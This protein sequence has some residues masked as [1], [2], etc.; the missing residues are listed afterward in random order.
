MKKYFILIVCFLCVLL[1]GSCKK[2]EKVIT[3]GATPSPH[4]EI[5]N[6]KAVQDYVKSK[7]YTL[8][9]KVYQDYIT[10]NKALNDSGL[11]ANYFQ[12]IPYLENQIEEF[13]YKISAACQV[14]NEP[15]NLY[16]KTAYTTDS[17]KGKTIYI[18]NDV[19]N[20][21]RA[22]KLLKSL[23]FIDSY[24]VTD[25]NPQHPV[26]ASTLGVKVECIAEGLLHKKVDEGGYAI[27]PG[28][29]ALTAW[30]TSTA[31]AYKLDGESSEVAYPNIIA[32]RTEDLNSEKINVLVEALS[33]P[34]VKAYIEET[35][36]PTVNFCFA[37][38]R[39]K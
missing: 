38:L 9:V 4:A 32:C 11:D 1:L 3:V 20:A 12:H 13:G 8:K 36:G 29:F 22:F 23:G 31:T 28:N 24:D 37:D 14:H 19:E 30:G 15:L 33:Q 18:I 21:E 6:S 25:Y 35:Y 10:P 2:N 16:G 39:K 26:F 5:L 7:G 17:I 27:I 34:E